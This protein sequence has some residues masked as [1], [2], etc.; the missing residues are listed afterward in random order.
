M[1]IR[2]KDTDVNYEVF[3]EGEKTLLILHG[4]MASIPAMSPIWQYFKATR[5]VIVL[6]FPGQGGKSRRAASCLGST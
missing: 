1:I 6:D 3:G 4:W 5:K 2:I